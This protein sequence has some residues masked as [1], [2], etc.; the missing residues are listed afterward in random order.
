MF[1]TGD[2]QT[3]VVVGVA[4]FGE[5]VLDPGGSCASIAYPSEDQIYTVLDGSGATTYADETVTL[6]RE[7]FLYIPATVA[8]ALSNPT[9]AR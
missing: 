4:R 5:V 2:P 9:K 3:S 7:D 1:G 8:H 6:K